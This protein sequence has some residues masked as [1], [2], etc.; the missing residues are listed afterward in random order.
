MSRRP[1]LSISL[2]LEGERVLLV[3][4]DSAAAGRNERLVAAGANVAWVTTEAFSAD[5]CER[6]RLVMAHTGDRAANEAIA[7]SARA[8][9]CLTYAHDM[10]ELSDFAMP[11]VISEGPL[12]IAISTGAAAPALSR[13]IREELEAL[14][15]SGR[16]AL[17]RLLDELES[18]RDS[19]RPGDPGR[20]ALYEVARRLHIR[21]S[22]E[23]DDDASNKS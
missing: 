3:G 14:F 7:V 18:R 12:Q 6:A 17:A 2:Y 20:M 8:V 11:A 16:D 21:G 4:S 19:M 15:S 1:T 9:G 23:V 10:P 13:R 22:V 5:M